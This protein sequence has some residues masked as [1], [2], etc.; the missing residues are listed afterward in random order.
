MGGSPLNESYP[1][2][3]RLDLNQHC[4]VHDR[5]LMAIITPFG[6]S[7]TTHVDPVTN[8]VSAPASGLS[9]LSLGQATTNPPLTYMPLS[10]LLSGHPSHQV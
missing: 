5:V 2:L 9:T 4:L 6:A 7:I 10:V 1:H 3:F 8:S